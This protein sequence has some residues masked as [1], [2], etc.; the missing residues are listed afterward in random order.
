MFEWGWEGGCLTGLGGGG[1]GAGGL[2]EVSG[3][4]E[5]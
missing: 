1:G 3:L 5:G 4:G 2:P